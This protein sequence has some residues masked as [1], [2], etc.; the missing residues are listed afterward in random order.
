[1]EQYFSFTEKLKSPR[2]RNIRYK[3]LLGSLRKLDGGNNNR[4]R[5]ISNKDMI[6]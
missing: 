1:M 6:G 3:A 5:N 2:I 4:E